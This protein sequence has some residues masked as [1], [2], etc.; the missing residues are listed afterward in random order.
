[1]PEVYSPVGVDLSSTHSTAQFKLGTVAKAS[2]GQEYVYCLSSGSIAQYALVCIDENFTARGGTTALAAE[3]NAPGWPQ[4]AFA[5]DVYGW[6]CTKGANFQGKLKDGVAANAQLYT[7]TSVGIMGSES[8]TGTPL[9][10]AGVR[11]AVAGS[12]AG[13]PGEIIAVRPHFVPK[14]APL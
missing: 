14:T 7:S 8:S 1:M 6:V 4:I 9:M 2:D 13:N 10:I 11:V 5:T 12:G 3:A